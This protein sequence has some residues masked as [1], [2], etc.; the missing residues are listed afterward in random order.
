ML[1]GPI[2]FLKRGQSYILVSSRHLQFIDCLNF[3]GS[4]QNLGNYITSM[5]V[6]IGKSQF[7]FRLLK[8]AKSLKLPVSSIKYSDFWSELHNWNSLDVDH[9][10]FRYIIHKQKITESEALKM[11]K[12]KRRPLRGRARFE[13]LKAS[14]FQKLF[15]L[16]PFS[17]Q[18]IS[19]RVGPECRRLD[20][21]G[22]HNVL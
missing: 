18:I 22:R 11:L 13:S 14:T 20:F 21:K 16:H 9:R 6:S 19:A 4:K 3:L 1:D 15:T 10:H 8:N 7:P 5:G 2:S 12:L 17:T